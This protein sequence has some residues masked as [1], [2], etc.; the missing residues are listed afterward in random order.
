MGEGTLVLLCPGSPKK[1]TRSDMQNIY[2]GTLLRDKVARKYEE[3]LQIVSIWI[4]RVHIVYSYHVSL[5]SGKRGR[6]KN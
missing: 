2:G 3:R 6:R 1:Q 4:L 5:K